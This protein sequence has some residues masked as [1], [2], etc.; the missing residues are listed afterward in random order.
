M[1]KLT[2]INGFVE[3]S[4][5]AYILLFLILYEQS[6]C[7][8]NVLIWKTDVSLTRLKKKVICLIN[9]HIIWYLHIMR[10]SNMI[11]KA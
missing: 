7:M 3:I 6:L 4:Q 5:F 10:I 9:F 2:L 8:N 11:I 1:I